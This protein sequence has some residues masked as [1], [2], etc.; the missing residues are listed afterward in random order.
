MVKLPSND[1]PDEYTP[2][3]L[4]PQEPQRREEVTYAIGVSTGMVVG[5]AEMVKG[6]THG[7]TPNLQEMLEVVPETKDGLS[8]IVRFNQDGGDEILY[9]FRQ[10][11]N[12]KPPRWVREHK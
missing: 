9:R 7:P 5:G 11:R 8:V 10:F 3:S 12:G 1:L 2:S 4:R 6:M